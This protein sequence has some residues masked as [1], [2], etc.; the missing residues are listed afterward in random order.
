[1]LLNY[2][3]NEHLFAFHSGKLIKLQFACIFHKKMFVKEEVARCRVLFFFVVFFQP[4]TLP[5]VIF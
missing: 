3:K 4:N 5:N 1:M 2:I